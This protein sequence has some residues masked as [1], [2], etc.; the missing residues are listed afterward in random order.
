[1]KHEIYKESAHFQIF[2]FIQFLFYKKFHLPKQLYT[3]FIT[4]Y[5]RNNSKIHLYENMFFGQ[6][7]MQ[8]FSKLKP[9]ARFI[10]FV[11]H[12]SYCP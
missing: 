1:M 9:L 11:P 2:I 7:E 10:S 5:K 12:Y 4:I 6:K 8:S 3:L